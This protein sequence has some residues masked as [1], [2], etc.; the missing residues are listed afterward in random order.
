MYQRRIRIDSDEK[1]DIISLLKMFDIEHNTWILLGHPGA[2]K[3]TSMKYL[4]SKI[5]FEE[6]FLSNSCNFPIVI[7]FRDMNFR[8]GGENNGFIAI[9]SH[10]KNHL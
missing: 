1:I 9:V 4:C 5:I 7:Q 10:I 3:T 6:A 2:G 8:R